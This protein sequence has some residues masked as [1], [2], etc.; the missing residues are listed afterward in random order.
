VHIPGTFI[1]GV[2]L[3]HS[4]DDSCG[5]ISENCIVMMVQLAD[6]LSVNFFRIAHYPN[7]RTKV[8]NYHESAVRVAM[9][10]S[11][12]FILITIFLESN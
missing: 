2:A 7:V 10:T 6:Q 1:P 5:Y 9:E 4:E 3:C 8:Y 11:K 12:L